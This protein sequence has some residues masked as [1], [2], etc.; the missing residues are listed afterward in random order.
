MF[1]FKQFSI[2]QDRCAMKVGTDGVLLGAWA[3]LY[4]KPYRIL[5]IGAGTGLI[6]L[7]LAQRSIAEHIDA[8]EIDI[9]AFA[10]CVENFENSAWCDRLYCYN[11]SLEEFTEEFFEE[12]TYDLIVSNPPFYTENYK[13]G[14]EQR[15]V[16]RFTDSLPFEQLIACTEGLLSEDGIFST[17]IPYKEEEAF[18]ELASE[19]GLYPFKICRIQGTP[20]TEIKRSMIALTRIP[21]EVTFENLIIEIARHQYTEEYIALTKDFY[22][23]IKK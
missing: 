20:E 21:A 13:T 16:A 4:N 14:N 3:P 23:K 8:V 11:A 2:Q 19:Y 18:I 6:A 17:I 22:L 5:D 9:E 7:M 15:D 1:S 12:T 10:Q